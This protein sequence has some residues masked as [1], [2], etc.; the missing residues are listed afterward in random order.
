[1]PMD[2]ST[3]CGPLVAAR[4]RERVEKYIR[5]GRDE[6]A[7]VAYG[8]GRPAGLKQGWDVEPTGFVDVDNRMRIAQEEIF[9]PVLALIPYADVTD[10]VGIANE[11]D[12]GLAG[13]V[14]SA[15]VEQGL[16][17]ARRVRTGTYTVNGFAMEFSAPFGGFKS[18][19]LGRELGP[20]GLA[21]YLEAKQIN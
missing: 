8:G 3:F 14:W 4:Q 16:D 10:A 19:G 13:S 18:S 7:R 9:G 1:D 12:Y 20:E 5:I 2:P 11:S 17:I 6:G 15:D 21:A